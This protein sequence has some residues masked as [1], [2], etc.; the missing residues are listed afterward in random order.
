MVYENSMKWCMKSEKRLDQCSLKAQWIWAIII[1]AT[2]KKGHVM[3][4]CFFFPHYIN[5]SPNLALVQ[6][7]HTELLAW[8]SRRRCCDG[9]PWGDAR[10]CRF[11]LCIQT[12]AV[13]HTML[14]LSKQK[15][16]NTYCTVFWIPNPSYPAWDQTPEGRVIS[17]TP[18]SPFTVLC[19]VLLL[20]GSCCNPQETSSAFSY[21]HPLVNQLNC[22][23]HYCVL[24][25][26]LATAGVQ[27]MPRQN[28]PQ[29]C[30]DY[31]E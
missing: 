31:F 28:A 11:C 24:F 4:W 13:A 7:E 9:E 29:V 16:K 23:A 1:L 27:S 2:G 20:K 10:E 19:L 17:R 18:L 5:F 21:L 14:I 8:S 22:P 3:L 25:S 12:L 15:L 26:K 30:T 6:H